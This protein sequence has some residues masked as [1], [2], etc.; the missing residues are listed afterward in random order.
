[1]GKL[2]AAVFPQGTYVYTGS[3]MNGLA[4]RLRRHSNRNKKLHWHIDY[5]LALSE[6]RIQR[7]FVYP[8]GRNQECRQN[9]RIG[10][11][12]GATALFGH[13]GATDCKSGCTSHLFY[14]AKPALS[15]LGWRGECGYEFSL[16]RWDRLSALHR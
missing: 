7:I 15:R 12:P 8:P 1:V 5:L 13:F 10:A 11:E 16:P 3:A 2:G 14:F 9:Q 4:A 6:A